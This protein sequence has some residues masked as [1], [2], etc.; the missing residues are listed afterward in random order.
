MLKGGDNVELGQ[1]RCA[2][3]VHRRAAVRGALEAQ[4][5]AARLDARRGRSSASESE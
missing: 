2:A 3:A 1:R 5:R 4:V